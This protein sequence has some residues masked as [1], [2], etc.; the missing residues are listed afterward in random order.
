MHEGAAVLSLPECHVK[1]VLHGNDFKVKNVCKEH[2]A[3]FIVA[4]V[5]G[6]LLHPANARWVHSVKI[7]CRIEPHTAS[8]GS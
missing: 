7:F 5:G 8:Q 3:N 2:C 1:A 4:E 6:V